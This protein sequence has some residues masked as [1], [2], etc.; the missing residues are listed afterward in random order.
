[1]QNNKLFCHFFLS[2]SI[3]YTFLHIL[4][5]LKLP[6]NYEYNYKG[7]KIDTVNDQDMEII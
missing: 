4:V 6:E 5:L 7:E 1:M 3:K 2:V